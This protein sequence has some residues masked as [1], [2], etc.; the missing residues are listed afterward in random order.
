MTMNT[1]ETY[2]AALAKAA[3]KKQCRYKKGDR[4]EIP[5]AQLSFV[6]G[7]NTIWVDGPDGTTVLRLKVLNGAIRAEHCTTSPVPHGDAI[8]AHSQDVTICIPTKK[9]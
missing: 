4:I 7:G 9:A 3:P 1:R 2:V 6:H 8:L 5:V